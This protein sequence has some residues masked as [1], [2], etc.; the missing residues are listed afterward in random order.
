MDEFAEAFARLANRPLHVWRVPSAARRL[1]QGSVL[2]DFLRADA[3]FSNVR[4]RGIGF[5]FRYPTLERGLEQVLGALD[6]QSA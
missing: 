6:E 5:R 3:V 2:S 1:V 4:L